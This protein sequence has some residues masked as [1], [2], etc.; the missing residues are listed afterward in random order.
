MSLVL[1]LDTGVA[2]PQSIAAGMTWTPA[3]EAPFVLQ[4][5]DLNIMFEITE[6]LDSLPE[7]RGRSQLIPFRTGQ[8]PVDRWADRR[9]IV[10]T[11]WVAGQASYAAGGW[12]DPALFDPALV[13]PT[14]VLAHPSP[15]ESYR[16]YLDSL[17][18]VLD[19]TKP[20]GIL[21]VPMD[22]GTTRWIN[23]KPAQPSLLGGDPIGRE[24]RPLS[25]EWEALDP[26]WYGGRLVV[27][28]VPGAP[29]VVDTLGTADV[30]NGVITIQ[31]PAADPGFVVS[32]P[33]GSI[34]GFTF[35]LSLSASERLVVDNAR[36]TATL[37]GATRRNV[38]SLLEG[39]RHGEY[40]RLAAG[41]NPVTILGSAAEVRLAF[42]VAFL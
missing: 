15:E 11:G 19:P 18:R 23:A 42:T 38:M 35:D 41:R 9:S 26:F 2:P 12:A 33:D 34:V 29:V 25:V 10:A 24:M 17:K 37:A 32:M 3:G 28:M 16:A 30:E 14:V 7:V 21:T 40:F 5:P 13:G 1:D 39:N 20:T 6:G 36:R 27:A 22:D 31:G 8:L 4:R